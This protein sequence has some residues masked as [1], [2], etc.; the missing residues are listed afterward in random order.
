MPKGNYAGLEVAHRQF[1]TQIFEFS[2]TAIFDKGT[3]LYGLNIAKKSA[4]TDGLVIVEG[5]M[6]AIVAHQNQFTNV[7]ASMGTALTLEQVSEFPEGHQ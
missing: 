4:R 2:K 3:I 1:G 5:Y 7:V 6:D